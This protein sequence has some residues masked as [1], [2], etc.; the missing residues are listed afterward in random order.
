[1]LLLLLLPGLLQGQWDRAGYRVGSTAAGQ[2]GLSHRIA[3]I[4]AFYR[5]FRCDLF[6]P[7]PL[8]SGSD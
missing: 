2:H 5:L 4:A 3:K 1:M 7:G 6:S 8:L